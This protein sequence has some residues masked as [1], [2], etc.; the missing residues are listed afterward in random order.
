MKAWRVISEV[1]HDPIWPFCITSLSMSPVP[2][3][4]PPP[5]DA[6]ASASSTS[7]RR[8]DRF[9]NNKWIERI[10]GRLW[11]CSASASRP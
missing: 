1:G 6:A 2:I 9:L 8:G 5:C 4:L 3:P 11:V 7:A 10:L